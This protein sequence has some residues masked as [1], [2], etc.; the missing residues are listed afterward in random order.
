MRR[1]VA[2]PAISLVLA[3]LFLGGHAVEAYGA[4]DCERHHG[5]PPDP[6]A[7]SHAVAQDSGQDTGGDGLRTCTCIGSCHGGAAAPMPGAAPPTSM[8]VAATHRDLQWKTTE[9]RARDRRAY[10]LPFP[11]APPRG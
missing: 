8:S 10:L 2:A 3:L 1:P 5:P 7:S 6:T 11:N 9:G 4:H